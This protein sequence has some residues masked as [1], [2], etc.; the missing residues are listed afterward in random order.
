MRTDVWSHG[1]HD[2]KTIAVQRVR[3]QNTV[4]FGPAGTAEVMLRMGA[5][6]HAADHPASIREIFLDFAS[7]ITAR[8][9]IE[10]GFCIAFSLVKAAS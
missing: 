7:I 9:M 5:A 6:G 10:Q 3:S 8:V 1:R 4:R 2:S